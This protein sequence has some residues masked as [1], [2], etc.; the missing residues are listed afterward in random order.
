[1][2]IILGIIATVVI[3]GVLFKSYDDN[4]Q[5]KENLKEEMKQLSIKITNAETLIS[6]DKGFHE[7]FDKTSF[8]NAIDTAKEVF[9]NPGYTSMEVYNS[10]LDLS[11]A[12]YDYECTTLTE[13]PI[14]TPTEATTET[15][16]AN[17]NSYTDEEVWQ[18]CVDRWAYYDSLVAD[19]YSADKYDT[20]VFNDGSTHFGISASEV[21][22]TWDKVDKAKMGIT[23]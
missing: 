4:L 8:Q 1:M 6:N 2:I 23:N 18:Y 12:N 15:T 21:Q 11:Q 3:G 7:D 5:A 13:M 16:S 9:E 19:G 17:T 20:E 10:T 22:A 14:E